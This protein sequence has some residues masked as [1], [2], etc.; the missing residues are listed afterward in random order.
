MVEDER[1]GDH[2]I[3]GALGLA[4]LRLAHPVADHLAAAKL[5]LLAVAGEVALHLDE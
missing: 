5:Y 3:D 1:V 4:A 2:G